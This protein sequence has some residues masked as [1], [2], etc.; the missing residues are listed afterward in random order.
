MPWVQVE[1]LS[2][3]AE[4]FNAFLT[5]RRRGRLEAVESMVHCCGVMES[6]EHLDSIGR[7][8]SQAGN[9]PLRDL[10]VSLVVLASYG[11][12]RKEKSAWEQ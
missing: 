12:C 2:V 11:D 4:Y 7:M 10:L 6:D 8:K 9:A 3:Y 5:L 1:R